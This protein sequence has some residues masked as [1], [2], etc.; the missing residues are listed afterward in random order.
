MSQEKWDELTL[1]YLAGYLDGE[2]C[3]WATPT[4]KIGVTIANTHKPSIDWLHATFAGSVTRARAPR[5]PNHRPCYGW[6]VAGRDADRLCK[7]V[8]PYLREKMEQAGLLIAI[9][10]TTGLPLQGRKVHP[11]VKAERT[12][13]LTL[14]KDTKHVSW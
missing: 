4:G 10:Q 7:A 6:Q 13:L 3:F 5:N 1:A 2:G 8:L 9:Q 14:L 12:R 11:D